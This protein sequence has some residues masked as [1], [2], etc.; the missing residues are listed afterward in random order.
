MISPKSLLDLNSF[1]A[2]EGLSK[3]KFLI[4][5]II[6]RPAS[7]IPMIHRNDQLMLIN[8][9]KHKKYAILTAYLVLFLNV[10]DVE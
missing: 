9:I 7:K 3:S 8:K 2:L 10:K 5:Q 4:C 1:K 6:C